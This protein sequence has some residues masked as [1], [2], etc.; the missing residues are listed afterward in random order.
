M[1]LKM[2]LIRNQ[3]KEAYS[4]TGCG[5]GVVRQVTTEKLQTWKFPKVTVEL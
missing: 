2:D 3:M 1:Y 5:Q 4:M